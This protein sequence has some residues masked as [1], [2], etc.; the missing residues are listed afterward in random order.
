MGLSSSPVGSTC[1]YYHNLVKMRDA[2]LVSEWEKKNHTSGVRSMSG[3]SVRVKEKHTSASFLNTPP[4]KILTEILYLYV[5]YINLHFIQK[6]YFPPPTSPL[7]PQNSLLSHQLRKHP[8]EHS[9]STSTLL[10]L[11]PTGLGGEGFL[12]TRGC[13]ARPWLYPLKTFKSITVSK[14]E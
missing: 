10:T 4:H 8:P 11:E 13:S 7:P 1:G 3:S 6:R 5:L 12:G 9:F 2:D 14:L